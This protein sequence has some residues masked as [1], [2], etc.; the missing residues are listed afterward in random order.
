MLL[1]CS[2]ISCL[3][4]QLLAG[5]TDADDGE[6]ATLKIG[7]LLGKN[8]NGDSAGT[9]APD[10]VN[11]PTKWTF[12]PVANFNGKVNVTYNVIDVKQG[13]TAATSEFNLAAVN[14]IP[15]LTG[16]KTDFTSAQLIWKEN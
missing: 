10:D 4:D 1:V 9:F 3:K 14:D 11:N 16:T 13:T 8:D 6:T 2:G 7:A 15:S 5:Y 12:T